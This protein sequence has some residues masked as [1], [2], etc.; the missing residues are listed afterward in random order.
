[1]AITTRKRSLPV[2][3]SNLERSIIKSLDSHKAEDIVSVDLRGKSDFADLMIVASGSSQRHVSAL[4][5]YVVEI[6]KK[7]G[8]EHV[9]VEGKESSDW[10]L[11]DAGNI[12]VH[13]FRP[14]VRSHYNLE[15]MWSVAIPQVEVAY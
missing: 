6:I 13:L 9:P 7:A 8:F 1:M 3:L 10:V 12:I 15:K 2:S 11:V 5:D 14:E 4:A